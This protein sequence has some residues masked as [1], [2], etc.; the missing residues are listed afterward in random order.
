MAVRRRRFNIVFFAM[1]AS[2]LAQRAQAGKYETLGA[3]TRRA[4]RERY[5]RGDNHTDGENTKH[6]RDDVDAIPCTKRWIARPPRFLKPNRQRA[7]ARA[8]RRG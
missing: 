2:E 3:L 8:S 6:E 4:S 5:T 7:L 1:P